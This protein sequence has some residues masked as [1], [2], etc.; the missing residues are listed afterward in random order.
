MANI[1]LKVDW[2]SERL[3]EK[4]D[5]EGKHHGIYVF[6]CDKSEYEPDLGFGVYDVIEVYWYETE[7][8]RNAEYKKLGK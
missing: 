2:Y 7:K 4:D 8:E 3:D 5:N 1:K 6:D